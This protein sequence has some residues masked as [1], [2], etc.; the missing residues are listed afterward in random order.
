MKKVFI[1]LACAALIASCSSTKKSAYPVVDERDVPEKFVKDFKRLRQGVEQ[2]KWEQI[3]SLTYRASF[4]AN[5]NK[6]RMQF[7]NAAT[8]SSWIIPL[9]YCE[10]I[11]NYVAENYKGYKLDEVVLYEKDKKTKA[12]YATISKKNEMKQLEFDLYQAFQ[13]EIPTEEMKK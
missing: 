7:T 8:E 9:E 3:D 1:L 5:G 4:D 13:K 12:Y 11:K 10:N 2:V 6:M